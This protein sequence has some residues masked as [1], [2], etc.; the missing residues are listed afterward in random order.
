MSEDIKN[1]E[2]DNGNLPSRR[3]FLKCSGAALTALTFAAAPRSAFAGN[4]APSEILAESLRFA[5]ALEFLHDEFY[6]A[7]LAE[8]RL[9]SPR[10]RRFFEQI[11]VEET[12]HVNFWRAISPTRAAKKPDFDF[13]A[14]GAFGDVFG[15]Y[16]TFLEVAQVFEDTAARAYKGLVEKLGEN[17]RIFAAALQIQASEA[18][19]AATVRQIR[20]GEPEISGDSPDAASAFAAPLSDEPLTAEQF[21]AIANLFVRQ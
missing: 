5:F 19:H 10:D 4:G 20:L 18:R 2:N 9:I 7:A 13:T 21:S 8:K 17:P 11:S 6:R 1:S 3:A 16:R 12:A 15:D 14:G